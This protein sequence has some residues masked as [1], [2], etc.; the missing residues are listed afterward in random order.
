MQR[1]RG[2][3]RGRCS[4]SDCVGFHPPAGSPTRCAGRDVPPLAQSAPLACKRP[5]PAADATARH[6]EAAQPP[7][8]SRRSE[9]VGAA[10]EPPL[11]RPCGSA[12]NDNT[13]KTPS[14][15]ARTPG[16]TPETAPYRRGVPP[17]ARSR[18]RRTRVSEQGPNCATHAHYS[19]RNA[20]T[21]VGYTPGVVQIWGS[22]RLAT[23]SAAPPPPLPR[24]T[25]RRP[26]G[27]GR[28]INTTT[29]V[30]MV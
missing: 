30:I 16:Q 12:R 9:N 19:S 10:R 6:C 13:G 29:S 4:V 14:V 23:L 17:V 7:K 18:A 27:E 24:R 2:A 20:P 15:T 5:P 26:P 28:R 1:P 25:P 3:P 11:R 21:I 8:Q 22:S